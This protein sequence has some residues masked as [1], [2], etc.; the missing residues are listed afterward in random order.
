MASTYS[1]DKLLANGE[2]PWGPLPADIY[3]ALKAEVFANKGRLVV[4]VIVSARGRLIDGHH[5]LMIAREYGRKTITEEEVRIDRNVKDSVAERLAAIGYQRNRR[6]TTSADMAKIARELMREY[7]WS[8]GIVA[9]K[10]AVTPAAVSQWLK[11]NPDPTFEL[12]E[13]TG[14]D[15]KTYT[16]EAAEPELDEEP[17]A[18]ATRRTMKGPDA[19]VANYRAALVNDEFYHWLVS[20]AS[21]APAD[22]VGRVA[23]D[24]AEIGMWATTASDVCRSLT[25]PDADAPFDGA[26]S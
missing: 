23:A 20:W 25:E 10:L 19:Q 6:Q 26:R 13:R 12:S 5:R 16:V 24:L 1:I 18:K 9:S 22:A 7:G 3:E 4:P 15:G 8:Q 11:A 2:Q 17:K 21:T 14:M